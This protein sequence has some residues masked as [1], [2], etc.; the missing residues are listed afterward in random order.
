MRP[1][2]T[3]LPLSL[4]HL[5]PEDLLLFVLSSLST[6][7]LGS[8]SASSRAL[9]GAIE[10]VVRSRLAAAGLST[11]PQPRPAESALAALLRAERRRSVERS[12][13]A[14]GAW[15]SLFIDAEEQL[16]LIH[17]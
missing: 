16:S 8:L 10:S 11:P 3:S 17:I 7:D 9:R 4:L 14:T 15:H 13:V 12:A 6:R 2:T 5:L 1:R